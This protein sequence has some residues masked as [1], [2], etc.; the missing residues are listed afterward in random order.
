MPHN[1]VSKEAVLNHLPSHIATSCGLQGIKFAKESK[2]SGKKSLV[3]EI[4]KQTGYIT[5]GYTGI[6]ELSDYVQQLTASPN[7]IS[8]N[9]HTS[10]LLEEKPNDSAETGNYDK[11]NNINQVTQ[12]T[13]SSV[14]SST[15][16][17][18]CTHSPKSAEKMSKLGVSGLNSPHSIF[19]TINRE[20]LE[21]SESSKATILPVIN[22]IPDSQSIP[23]MSVS[24]YSSSTEVLK[25]YRLV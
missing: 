13:N 3:P 23:S 6:A 12:I 9:P 1:S 15:S 2:M 11:V 7:Q 8:D 18:S 10:A 4:S 16:S 5:N 17:I 24:I 25:T 22:H 19:C 21:N 20:E 14:A